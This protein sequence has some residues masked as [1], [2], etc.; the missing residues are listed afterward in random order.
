M[1][2]ILV[3]GAYGYLGRV[4]V[5]KLLDQKYYVIGIDTMLYSK[6]YKKKKFK[7]YVGVCEDKYLLEK[8][9]KEN[10]KIYAVIHLS[11][12][13]NDPT[14]ILSPKLTNN[15]NI[16]ATKNIVSFSK[17]FKIKRFLFAS[18]CSVYGFTGEKEIVNEK[19]KLNPISLYAKSK[20]RAE[21]IILKNNKQNFTTCCL[22]KGTLF[23]ASPRMRFDLVV[24]TMT[25]SAFENRK[26]IV[27]G[28]KQW[29]PFLH[30][31]D[32]AE[33]YIHL[34]N[35]NKNKISGQV[36]NVGRNDLNLRIIDL[37]NLIA[38]ITKTKILNSKN[39]DNRSYK[40][41][42]DKITEMT[43]WK[44]EKN[45]LFGVKQIIRLFKNK[46]I[47]NYRDINYYNIKRLISH[48]NIS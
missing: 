19:S 42:F 25:G 28:G 17:K 21:K 6:I 12:V 2:K 3:T 31:E 22:R 34:L 35:V 27:N 16:E 24:N 18:S 46:K 26:I 47:K 10:K 9:F 15:S 37:A 48:L 14:A 40:V 29:R 43:D 23:G 7:T 4:L 36:F 8:I 13:S 39:Y 5:K 45:I 11:G 38:K 33:A 20:I 30:V 1:K 44:A 32:A 41:S